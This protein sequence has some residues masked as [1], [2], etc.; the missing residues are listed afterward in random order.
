MMY[1]NTAV[2]REVSAELKRQEMKP[3]VLTF[4]LGV[5]DKKASAL[6]RGDS[7]WTMAELEAVAEG[8][9]V[10]LFEMVT[11]CA[12]RLRKDPAG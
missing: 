3:K 4:W 6:C 2:A 10:D 1:L 7:V 5:G 8:M 9:G 11:R 12:A